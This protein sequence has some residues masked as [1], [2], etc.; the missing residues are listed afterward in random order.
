[1]AKRHYSSS[2]MVKEHDS[3]MED[4]MTGMKRRSKMPNPV[5]NTVSGLESWDYSNMSNRG[6]GML[7]DDMNAPANLPRNVKDEYYPRVGF[8]MEQGQI[9]DLFSGEQEMMHEDR[10]K[11][12][13]VFKPQKY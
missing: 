11:M 10:K 9:G 6:Y 12:R 7:N 13:S 2:R 1:M 8:V 5:P 4:K 3:R